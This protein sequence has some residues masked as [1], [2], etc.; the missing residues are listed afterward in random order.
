MTG[1]SMDD[2]IEALNAAQVPVGPIND[3]ERVFDDPHIKARGMR[4]GPVATDGALLQGVASP[5][6]LSQTPP[7]PPK[8]APELGA[9]T[10]A[11]LSQL[12][13]PNDFDILALEAAGA[14]QLLKGQP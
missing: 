7:I 11:V 13:D 9:D 2:W 6:K 12:L 8:A 14:V 1:R 10:F 4:T 5:L 3:L